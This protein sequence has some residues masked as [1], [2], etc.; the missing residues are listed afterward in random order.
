[1]EDRMYLHVIILAAVVL[2]F[3]SLSFAASHA[4]AEHIDS[5]MTDKF[6]IIP[7][8]NPEHLSEEEKEWFATFQEGT[9]YVQGWQEIT[10]EILETVKQENKKEELRRSLTNLGIRIGCEW[11]KKNDVRKIDTDMLSE[12]GSELQETAEKNPDE[13]PIVIANIQ[14]KVFELVE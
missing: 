6:C 12:W 10:A 1:M 5:A 8:P 14:Q 13:L 3:S 11:S 4:F 9:F 2:H 7:L